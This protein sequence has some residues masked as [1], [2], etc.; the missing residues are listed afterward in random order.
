MYSCASEKSLGQVW[1]GMSLCKTELVTDLILHIKPETQ[2]YRE[3][4]STCGHVTPLQMK[5]L[6]YLKF[7]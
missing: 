5:S 3:I 7:C 2:L 1:A 4:E 6:N